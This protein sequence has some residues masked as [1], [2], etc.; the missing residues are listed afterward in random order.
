MV[1]AALFIFAKSWNQP[2]CLSL[3]DLI[4][5]E[6]ETMEYYSVLRRN[7]FSSPKKTL[8]NLKYIL[9]SEIRQFEKVCIFYDSSYLIFWKR[10]NYIHRK[11]ISI[12][13]HPLGTK[14]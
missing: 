8:R 13:S 3:G 7:E 2:R 5:W 11:K 12:I 14:E 1:I 10:Q 4:N 9:L 6:I